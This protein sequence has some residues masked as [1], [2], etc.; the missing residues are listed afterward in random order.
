METLECFIGLDPRGVLLRTG[1][2]L[3]AAH[4]WN[5]QHDQMA[6]DSFVRSPNAT[7]PNIATWR[8]ADCRATLLAS[9]EFF[10]AVAGPKPDASCTDLTRHF[11]NPPSPVD[12]LT[13]RPDN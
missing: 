11:A 10:V 2:V 5:Y 4:I 9:L 6:L 3:K 13:G 8:D 7:W 12:A 1:R